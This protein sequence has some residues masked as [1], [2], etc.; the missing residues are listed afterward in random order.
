MSN[1]VNAPIDLRD[2]SLE[3]SREIIHFLKQVPRNDLTQPVI[4]Q[5]IRS[6]TGVGANFIEA[7]NAGSK[8]D[9]RNKV[10][11]SK[12]EASETLYWLQLLEEFT[13]LDA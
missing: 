3:F 11:I 7:K 10:L 2:R 9:F 5:L 4:N 8:R 12:K 6:S 13:A 1:A